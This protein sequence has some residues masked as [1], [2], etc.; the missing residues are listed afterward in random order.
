MCDIANTKNALM[1][2]FH[3]HLMGVMGNGPT[4]SKSYVSDAKQYIAYY[5][6]EVDEALTNFEISKSSIQ[7]YVAYLR[8]LGKAESTIERQVHGLIA[9]WDFLH[10][11]GLA[12]ES[13]PYKKLNL[14]IK[15]V[16]NP[17]QPLSKQ[18][19]KR[20]MKGLFDELETIW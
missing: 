1:K 12:S 2:Y 20:F 13:I 7:K 8:E 15:P 18:D 4:T 10:S 5:S 19:D 6:Q 14:N 3:R 9:F 16:I 11:Q 17:T